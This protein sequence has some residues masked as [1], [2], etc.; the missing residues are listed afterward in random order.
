[1]LFFHNLSDEC[2]RDL[3]IARIIH[4]VSKAKTREWLE[5]KFGFSYRYSLTALYRGMERAYRL[6][7]QER[8]EQNIG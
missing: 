6:N 2:F 3:V 8:L 4:P 1:M 5:T 7:Y